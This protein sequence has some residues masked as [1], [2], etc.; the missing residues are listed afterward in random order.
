MKVLVT[1][2]AGLVGHH[3]TAELLRAHHAVAVLDN[4]STGTR[5]ALEPFRNDSRFEL[6]E[7]DVREASVVRGASKGVAS[8]IHLAAIADVQYSIKHPR[9]TSEVNVEGTR[10]VVE[11]CVRNGVKSIVF[12]SSSAVYGEA[13]RL[14]ISEADPLLPL[15]P[16]A[17]TKIAG[18]RICASRPTKLSG[19][20]LR[21]FNIYGQIRGMASGPVV[22]NFVSRARRGQPPI[23]FGDGDQTRDFVHVDD[24]VRV[25]ADNLRLGRGGV[26]NIGSGKSITINELAQRILAIAGRDD[27]RPV[28]EPERRGDIRNSEADITSARLKLKF[29]PR[30]GLTEGLRRLFP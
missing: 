12:A 22:E 5:A 21:F 23:I 17:K 24:V 27:L 15:S 19:V 6:I 13:S 16:Y 11:A 4:F 20:S 9:T 18:E 25:I 3:L 30:V 2:G 26:F 1:G 8:V 10:N 14:P 7:G 29:R 28:R